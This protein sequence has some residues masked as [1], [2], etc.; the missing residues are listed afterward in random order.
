[1]TD[2]HTGSVCQ[3]SG[4]DLR[5]DTSCAGVGLEQARAQTR[6][7]GAADSGRAVAARVGGAWRPQMQSVCWL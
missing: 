2:Q 5:G 3:R 4:G 7:G 1:M 6:G